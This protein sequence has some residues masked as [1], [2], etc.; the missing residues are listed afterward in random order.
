MKWWGTRGNADAP[1][2]LEA[3][4]AVAYRVAC[5]IALIA[6]AVAI[7]AALVAD[8]RVAR[9]LTESHARALDAVVQNTAQFLSAG[10]NTRVRDARAL[11]RTPVIRNPSPSAQDKRAALEDFRY[12]SP[13]FVWVAYIDT[14]TGLIVAAT[15]GAEEGVTAAG[16]PVFEEG[17][18][19]SFV[20][21]VHEVRELAQAR[22]DSA[23][24]VD[25]L[26]VDVGVPVLSAQ[27]ETVGVIAAVLEWRWAEQIRQHTQVPG[28]ETLVV[29]LS[30][31]VILGR[32]RVA[33]PT[34]LAEITHRQFP[35]GATRVRWPEAGEQLTAIAPASANGPYPTLGWRV[36]AHEPMREIN[37]AARQVGLWVAL[38]CAL[39]GAI[40]AMLVVV[41][42]RRR[43]ATRRWHKADQPG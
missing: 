5:C 11:S 4:D 20:G 33:P 18:Q 26:F 6:I 17:R 35:Q 37:A 36:V 40:S 15:G 13:D 21:P 24:P 8:S 27:G 14:H 28:I 42:L 34:L 31:Q 7:P 3:D 30:G 38:S 22:G 25:R 2:M 29:D 43:A 1:P 12:R 39:V 32:D 16:Q 9:A 41:L 19:G 10:L 23:D